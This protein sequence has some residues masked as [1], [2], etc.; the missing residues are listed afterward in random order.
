LTSF[1]AV[2]TSQFATF[3]V[4]RTRIDYALVSAGLA[5]AVRQCGF[6]PLA[7][8]LKS[9]HR[10]LFLVECISELQELSRSITNLE[11]EAAQLRQAEQKNHLSRYL[12]QKDRAEARAIRQIMNAEA[13][14]EMWR[15][16]RALQPSSGRG[17]TTI[18]VPSNGD[19][20]TSHYKN[21]QSWK[22]ITD[23]TEI[24]HALICRNRLHFGQA[25]GKFATIPPF[26]H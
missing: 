25:H 15:Q 14:K 18:K 5:A 23:P 16:L 21:C 9:D 17:I 4:G 13:T 20:S 2:G 11:K 6:E 8:R 22:L 7:F 10:G 3:I 19:L 24:R 12:Q 26:S 1:T